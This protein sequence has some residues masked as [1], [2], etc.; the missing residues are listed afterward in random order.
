LN[1]YNGYAA[2]S[3]ALAL[4]IAS[5]ASSASLLGGLINTGSDS[6]NTS[7]LISSNSD[8]ST[9]VGGTNGISINTGGLTGGLG[10]VPTGDT[11][12]AGVADISTGTSSGG[13]TQAGVSLLGGGGTSISTNP[14]G[15]LGNGGSGS[16]T[17][18][19]LGGTGGTP[20]TPGRPG[21]PGTPG[22]PG[23]AG[24]PGGGGSNG[25]TGINGRNGGGFVIP[26][27]ASNRLRSILAMLAQRDWIRMVNGRAI[28]LANFGTAEVSSWL[29]QRDW[30]GLNAALPQY[31]QDIA[32]LRQLLANCRSGAQ[33]Q[34]LDVRD[35]N[36][37]IGIDVAS[38]GTPVLYML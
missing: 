19:G 12:A 15:L 1:K 23:F 7:D 34:A 17:L 13:G 25:L 16:L 24:L 11:G 36:R 8:G 22:T 2:A 20:G 6:G 31:A 4:L 29:P 5:P 32:T 27:N 18:P 9:G 21:T 35:L 38:N 28:C 14:F 26:G 30:A 10:G 37:V 3:I 33:R